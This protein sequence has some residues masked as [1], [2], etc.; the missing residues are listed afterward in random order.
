MAIDKRVPRK[1]N[2][3]KDNRIRKKDEFNDALNISITDDYG[4]IGGDGGSA[5][6]D[7]N[8]FIAEIV[9]AA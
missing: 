8:S 7:G 3:S 4:N 1:L 9:N 6:A 5:T 2:S